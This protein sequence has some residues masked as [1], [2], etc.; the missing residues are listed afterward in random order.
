MTDILSS[1]LQATFRDCDRAQYG[2]LHNKAL[3]H[4]G[5]Y[6]DIQKSTQ[7]QR[8]GKSILNVPTVNIIDENVPSYTPKSETTTNEL[9]HGVEIS[10]EE[11]ENEDENMTTDPLHEGCSGNLRKG[12]DAFEDFCLRFW[13][14]SIKSFDREEYRNIFR[15]HTL[16]TA[17]LCISFFYYDIVSDTLLAIQYYND[18]NFR[19]FIFTT[20]FIAL[21][22]FVVNVMNI[23]LIINRK[24]CSWEDSKQFFISNGK[25]IKITQC[26]KA[27]EKT[28]EINAQRKFKVKNEN[29]NVEEDESRE[30]DDDGNVSGPLAKTLR[31]LVSFPLLSGTVDRTFTHIYHGIKSRSKF[32]NDEMRKKHYTYSLE[33]NAAETRLKIIEAFMEATPQLMLQIYFTLT[34]PVD[35]DISTQMF[36]A[37]SM[38]GSWISVTA[39]VLAYTNAMYDLTENKV[40]VV[41]R[42]LRFVQTASGI[43]LRI[44]LIPIFTVEFSYYVIVIVFSH[45]LLMVVTLLYRECTRKSSRIKSQRKAVFLSIF[46]YRSVI[47]I[48]TS[49]TTAKRHLESIR[50]EMLYN[51]LVY[52]ENLTMFA[53]WISTTL[54][55]GL[56]YNVIIRFIATLEG[57]RVGS[58]LIRHLYKCMCAK[59]K[60]GNDL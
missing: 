9:C 25:Q 28:K 29:N 30:A 7:D 57:L 15:A 1:G 42:F 37:A 51:F 34:A 8:V 41:Y 14:K 56:Y 22:L 4:N 11:C 45:W 52:A 59:Q 38:L 32:T 19:A 40:S 17:V 35:E 54:I 55:T 58:F 47:L 10:S 18:G 48:F 13:W 3:D 44:V 23:Y 46:S 16:V 20:A 6:I 39:S 60:L 43:G 53:L 24:H 27:N 31:C 36:R 49:A 5:K 2:I 21:P 26:I 33:N 12:Y 50:G